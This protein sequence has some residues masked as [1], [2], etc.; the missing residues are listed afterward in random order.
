MSR[1]NST[2]LGRA[3]FQSSSRSSRTQTAPGLYLLSSPDGIH[4]SKMNVPLIRP[5]MTP[6]GYDSPNSA[7]WSETEQMY[8]FYYRTVK[9]FSASQ[10]PS[11]TGDEPWAVRWVSRTTSKDLERWTEPVEMSFG[12]TPPEH[13][14]TNQT[15][16]YSRAPHIYVGL[17]VRL[18]P[19]RHA[20]SVAEAKA[21]GV[22]PLYLNAK[23]TSDIVLLTS[24]GGNR[25][26]RTFM[27]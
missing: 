13:F 22:P 15:S 19:A 7:F 25:Y 21:L 1:S 11:Q 5:P 20:I 23:G 2:S 10:H 4:W 27:E 26:D 8:V 3:G 12:D 24:R 18:L 14:Y 6:P 16:P 17:P 9:S